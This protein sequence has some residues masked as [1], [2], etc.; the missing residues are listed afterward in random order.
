MKPKPIRKVNLSLMQTVVNLNNPRSTI[1]VDGSRPFYALLDELSLGS[2]PTMV[3]GGVASSSSEPSIGYI[4]Q[5][6][7][8]RKLGGGGFG[9]VYLARDTVSRV[10][11]AIKTLHPLL[12]S[13]AEEMDQL[14]EK[15]A[16]VARLSHPNIAS[17]LVLHPVQR[18]DIHDP[19]A[20]NELRLVPGDSVMV[21][22]YAPGVTLSKWRR[23]F[24]PG[25][26][27]HPL[28][29]EIGRQIASALDYA[30]GEKIVHRDIK[31]S[32]VMVE[33]LP[34]EVSQPSKVQS[35]DGASS[36]SEPPKIRARI[37]DFGLAAEIRSSMSRVSTEQG[38]TSGTRPY[39][40]PEQWAG[41]N[42]DG[43][44]DQYALA[45]LLYELFCGATPFAGVFET[46]DPAIMKSA[47]EHDLPMEFDGVPPGVN[48]VFRRALAKSP[49]DRFP[50]CSEFVETL[51]KAF[52][53]LPYEITDG[54][55][56]TT[57]M[58]S[59]KALR[60][61]L[62]K[63]PW[64]QMVGKVQSAMHTRAFRVVAE[65]LVVAILGGICSRLFS[66]N[67]G[68]NVRIDG[69][70]LA[71]RMT[72]AKENL[73]KEE[74]VIRDVLA[75]HLSCFTVE[76]VPGQNSSS[77]LDMDPKTEDVFVNVRA[78]LD[79]EKYKTFAKTV[80]DKLGTIAISREIIKG[81]L[82]I[83]GEGSDFKHNLFL[84]RSAQPLSVFVIEPNLRLPTAEVLKFEQNHADI[85][86]KYM[87]V[88][89]PAVYVSIKGKE[90]KIIAEGFSPLS[91]YERAKW[92]SST[93]RDS[94][95]SIDSY[96]RLAYIAP[97]LWQETYTLNGY[98]TVYWQSEKEN[99]FPLEH[100]F[101]ISLG[102]F[103]AEELKDVGDLG[104]KLGHIKDG[105]FIKVG[106]P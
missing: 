60:E 30:H 105:K 19:V 35:S 74:A 104:I 87:D 53:G 27:P 46:G 76:T 34:S 14:G 31:P 66:G 44:T 96:N 7:L 73:S 84:T 40:A 33:T 83:E 4:D 92:N 1:F 100:R 22:R 39:M 28:V 90:G 41:R 82:S 101:R 97:C 81:N 6:Q 70:T 65:I 12:K 18:I 95:F 67:G 24:P 59:I 62:A 52:A 58:R 102:K 99:S 69:S 88:G 103:T 13:N 2:A 17:A 85:V 45:C 51:A 63:L 23:Q 32:N 54:S 55:S 61:S 91:S 77:P 71:S 8:V 57:P 3:G 98:K 36:P 37:L 10:D 9:V 15:F 75:Q 21:M 48:N 80:V 56:A 50:T 94:V 89:Y 26:I 68:Q 29:L 16:L 86:E 20:S 11:V 43:R 78:R 79:I 64:K 38:D 25:K 49:A 42:Q 72:K 106:A 5:Y 93:W 47:V